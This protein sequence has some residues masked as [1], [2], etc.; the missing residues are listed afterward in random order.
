MPPM[1]IPGEGNL[2]S[3]SWVGRARTLKDA[4]DTETVSKKAK[5]EHVMELCFGS[6]VAACYYSIKA[7]PFSIDGILL[8]QQTRFH[9]KA[10]MSSPARA[11]G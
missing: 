8:C 5:L 3:T 4:A 6:V 10:H 9:L 11:R 7:F 1:E 2:R